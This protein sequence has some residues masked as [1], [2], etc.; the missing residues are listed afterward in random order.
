MRYPPVFV[1]D[2][3][4]T[5]NKICL[6]TDSDSILISC[7]LDLPNFLYSILAIKD[8]LCCWRVKSSINGAPVVVES[9]HKVG[10]RLKLNG[11]V[12]GSWYS[13]LDST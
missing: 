10:Q 8:V 7:N 4:M 6:N 2:I 11:T 9:L 13:G 3:L 5:R 1:L 12:D